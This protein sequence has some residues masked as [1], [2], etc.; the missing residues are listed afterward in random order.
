MIAE[1]NKALVVKMADEIFNKKNVDAL[2]DF[3][4]ED[5]VDHNPPPGG[6]PGLQGLKDAMRMFTG[7]FPDMSFQI[8][9]L[10][11]EED[12]VV[13]RITSTGTHQGDLMGI[14]ATGKK[15][16]YGEIHV[17]W[18]AGGKIVEHWGIEDQMGMM[19]QLG[20]IPS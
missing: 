13:M 16:S 10:I 7:A 17:G 18:I 4:A 1:E 6:K 2:G 3:M 14:A 12:K 15:I 8:E 5:M 11:A 9:D 20:V 19:Q